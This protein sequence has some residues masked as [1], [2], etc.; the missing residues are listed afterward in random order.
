MTSTPHNPTADAPHS[1]PL[2][3][4]RPYA[5]LIRY[6]AIALLV[7]ALFLFM[8]GLPVRKGISAMEGFILDLGIWGMVIYALVYTIATVLLLPGFPLTVAAG[9]IFGPLWGGWGLLWGTLTVAVG[10]NFGAALALLIGRYF[11]RDKVA[12]WAESYPRFSAVDRAIETGGWKIVALL[13]L[14]PALPFNLQNYLYGLTGIRFWTCVL[15]SVVAM[16]PGTFLYVYIG[17]IGRVGAEAAAAGGEGTANLG[18]YI[19]LGLGLLATVVVT[20]YITKAAKRALAEQT[21]IENAEE[22]ADMTDENNQPQTDKTTKAP[23]SLRGPMTLLTIAVLA[24]VLSACARL[25]GVMDGL[26][27]PPAVVMAEAYK[28]K[29]DGPSFDHSAFDQLLE[30]YVDDKGGVDYK[31]LMSERKTLQDYIDRIGEAP[32]DAMGRNQKLALLINAYNA[33]TLELI[34]EYWNDGKLKSINHMSG[35][36]KGEYIPSDKRWTDQRWQ[37]GKHT[38][39]LN[40]I[41]HEQIRPKFKEPRIHW[42]LVCAAVGCPPLRAEAYTAAKLEKQLEDQ[43]KYVH[44]RDKWYRLDQDE[45]KVYLTKLYSWYGGDFEQVA[46]SVLKYVADYDPTLKKMLEQGNPPRISWL[47]Y[48]WS[49]NSQENIH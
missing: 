2:D 32:F 45:N 20:V 21:N 15:T 6:L 46:G 19:M 36:E 41:E 37:V 48:D 16:L 25:T 1:G 11:A 49:L 5:G 28:P 14:S 35:L 8:G 7:I 22:S 30:K 4:I 27:G 24:V 39:S 10:A 43:A 9:A 26:F 31:G 38:W 12:K 42:V 13:R 34:L 44:S 3:R 17:Y 40:Q 47:D 18:K 33:F 29:P 23:A